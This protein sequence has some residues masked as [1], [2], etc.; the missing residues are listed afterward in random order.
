MEA[1]GRV[2]F[3]RVHLPAESVGDLVGLEGRDPS[4]FPDAIGDEVGQKNVAVRGERLRGLDDPFA[5]RGKHHIF[6]D[7]D[8]VAVQV[9]KGEGGD[10]AATQTAVSAEHN[11]DLHFGI[12]EDFHKPGDF[13][14]GGNGNV[15]LLLIV[16][17]HFEPPICGDLQ[18]V[19]IISL[20]FRSLEWLNYVLHVLISEC[21]DTLLRY[22]RIPLADCSHNTLVSPQS[23]RGECFG[24]LRDKI[25]KALV[26]GRILDVLAAFRGKS[27]R[28]AHDG[29]AVGVRERIDGAV[30]HYSNIPIS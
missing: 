4:L 29:L 23:G 20:G 7:V 30:N 17:F 1:V 27:G 19:N 28:L 9:V 5:V 15:S 8:D 16:V 10:F 25:L 26:K 11:G 24:A 6:R 14:F 18:K 13:Q 21:Y 3:E 22:H 12:A 2:D